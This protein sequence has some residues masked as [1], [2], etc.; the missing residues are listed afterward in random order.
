MSIVEYHL[1]EIDAWRRGDRGTPG[2][3]STGL[4]YPL[5]MKLA[6]KDHEEKL[7]ALGHEP[8]IV[9]VREHGFADG[10]FSVPIL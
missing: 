9:Y 7:I 1:E 3:P 5:A 4:R 10:A 2:Q 8:T 6:I